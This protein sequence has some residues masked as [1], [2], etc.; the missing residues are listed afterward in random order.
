VIVTID[1]EDLPNR[2]ERG[3][4]SGGTLI[5]VARLLEMADQAEIIPTVLNRSGV[6]LSLRRSRRIASRTQT[7]AL[8]ARDSG[9]APPAAHTHRR[10]A[11]AIT[12]G[13][14]LTAIGAMQL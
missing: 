4:A 8:I 3:T 11:N 7:V 10:G 13:N 2:T 6:V 12:S 14:G 5:R 1:H 9:A